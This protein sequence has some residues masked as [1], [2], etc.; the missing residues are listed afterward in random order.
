MTGKIAF[1]DGLWERVEAPIPAESR[2]FRKQ[3]EDRQAINGL[4]FVL[5]KGI[6]WRRL[7]RELD[8]ANRLVRGGGGFGPRSCSFGGST[9]D[10]P[11]RPCLRGKQMPRPDDARGLPPAESPSACEKPLRDIVLTV[12]F[13]GSILALPRRKVVT[14]VGEFRSLVG[15]LVVGRLSR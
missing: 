6:A 1:G 8:R 14:V 5:H 2:R 13:E 4:L 12:V 7:P 15:L 11:R 3:L 9:P 10:L